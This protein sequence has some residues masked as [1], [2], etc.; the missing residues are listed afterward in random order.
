MA[1]LAAL[2]VGMFLSFVSIPAVERALTIVKRMVEYVL[3]RVF[4]PFLPLYVLGF[5]LEVKYKGVFLSMFEQYGSAVV[6]IVTLQ[7][8]Y[9]RGFI[10]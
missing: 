8:L 7:V 1:L 3:M 4:I 2:G 6:V 10:W 5:L 9:L